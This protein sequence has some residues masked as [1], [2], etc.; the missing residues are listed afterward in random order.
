M[1]QETGGHQRRV[2]PCQAS[3]GEEEMAS[4][5]T[6]GEQRRHLPPLWGEGA[7]CPRVP[8]AG[9]P[10]TPEAVGKRAAFRP[11]LTNAT[12][13]P[14]SQKERFTPSAAVGSHSWGL[15][16]PC[17]I[18]GRP[19]QA[20]VDTGSTIT[21]LW[22]DVLPGTKAAGPPGWGNLQPEAED[23]DRAV[24]RGPR[25]AGAHRAVWGY[26]GETPL[27]PHPSPRRL[28]P[29]VGLVAAGV[30]G[31]W[32]DRSGKRRWQHRASPGPAGAMVEA[33]P[34]IGPVLRW[35]AA[36]TLPAQ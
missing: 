19:F 2:T 9:A 16:L 24:R 32:A 26:E 20:L 23:G 21:L 33:D 8:G 10:G 28:Y 14:E 13:A 25:Q 36:G 35:K 12:P 1:C 34:N 6:P 17:L 31:M 27:L 11:P 4:A 18:E 3:D 7:H 22:P 30:Q 15:F 5:V 29:G